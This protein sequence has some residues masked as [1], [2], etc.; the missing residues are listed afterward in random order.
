VTAV[1]LVLFAVGARRIP[2]STVG[3]QQY[4][5]PT[6]QLL[7]AVFLFHESFSTA[8]IV[9][10]A[11]IW[12]ALAIYGADGLLAGRRRQQSAQ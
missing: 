8:R 7:T 5:A 1:P 11:M 2:L 3:L 6:M 4:I 12:A 10:F 9:G